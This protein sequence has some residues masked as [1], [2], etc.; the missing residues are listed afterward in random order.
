VNS[1]EHYEKLVKSGFF[2]LVRKDAEKDT[3]G[4]VLEM[5][6]KHFG[7]IGEEAIYKYQ[8]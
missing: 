6:A 7:F 2:T 1:K 4:D 5:L 3:K 8:F